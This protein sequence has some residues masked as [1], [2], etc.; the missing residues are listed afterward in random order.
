MLR[1]KE[2]LR[3]LKGKDPPKTA[4]NKRRIESEKEKNFVEISF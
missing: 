1:W 4:I 2:L 3:K